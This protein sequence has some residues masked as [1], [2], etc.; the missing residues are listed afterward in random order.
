M[1]EEHEDSVPYKDV[2]DL[3]KNLEEVKGIGGVSIKELYDSMQKLTQTMTQMLEI[4]G[5]AVEQLKL[6]EKEVEEDA[7]KHQVVISKLDRVIGQNRTIA[8]GMVAI[9]EMIKEKVM[10][11][12]KEKEEAFQPK[13]K[14]DSIFKPKA[15]PVPFTPLS[16]PEWQQH[17]PELL[18]PADQQQAEPAPPMPFG[19]EEKSSPL[20]APFPEPPSIKEPRPEW[21]L[22]QKPMA[23][24]AHQ[25]NEWPMPPTSQTMPPP[26][27][28]MEMPP[29]QPEPMPDFDFPEEPFPLEDKPKKK[30]I[31]GI[32]KK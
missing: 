25:A 28:G 12:P 20:F 8:E 5:T 6:E 14:D 32:F 16:Q 23:Q 31:F 4:F 29:M 18:T 21:Q 17:M 3:K 2:S 7:K 27:F 19:F 26:Q 30:G 13:I 24:D 9:V 22:G 15:E 10:D 1:P 11:Q